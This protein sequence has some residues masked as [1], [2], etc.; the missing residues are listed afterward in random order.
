MFCEKWYKNPREIYERGFQFSTS[1]SLQRIP[2]IKNPK[3]KEID[4]MFHKKGV[5]ET[6]TMLSG[7]QF[8]T[9]D[10]S[11]STSLWHDPTTKSRL[12]TQNI[13]NNL[14]MRTT[15]HNQHRQQNNGRCQ[16][17]KPTTILMTTLGIVS[18]FGCDSCTVWCVM[19]HQ[20]D[21]M[22]ASLERKEWYESKWTKI[23]HNKTFQDINCCQKRE[24]SEVL[25]HL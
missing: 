1:F 18:G 25:D 10:I 4:W 16:P 7:R 8:Q 17:W 19:H 15:S 23:A 12:I 21:V 9:D 2:L 14:K 11:M 24:Y 5:F 13:N 22:M 6:C 3:S 20:W